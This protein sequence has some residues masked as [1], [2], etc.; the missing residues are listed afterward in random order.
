M[1]VEVDRDPRVLEG[2]VG[3][4]DPSLMTVKTPLCQVA[5][6]WLLCGVMPTTMPSLLIAM[7]NSKFGRIV[8][9]PSA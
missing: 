8:V 4:R 1:V 3:R 9:D 7:T 6:S 2:A 5:S